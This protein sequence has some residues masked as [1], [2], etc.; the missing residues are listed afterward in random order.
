MFVI[1]LCFVIGFIYG[2]HAGDI[3]FI[4]IC[5]LPLLGGFISFILQAK[6]DKLL[7]DLLENNPEVKKI[8]KERER[9]CANRF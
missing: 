5:G 3:D 9:R 1:F 4:V 2:I 6:S 7:E 8:L